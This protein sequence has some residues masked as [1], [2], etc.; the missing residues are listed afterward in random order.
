MIYTRPFL[1]ALYLRNNFYEKWFHVTVMSILIFTCFF[2][3]AIWAHYSSKKKKKKK[4]MINQIQL[5]RLSCEGEI[6]PSKSGVKN[7]NITINSSELTWTSLVIWK[8]SIISELNKEF[9][10]IWL[11]ERYLI[12][13][14]INRSRRFIFNKLTS[15][16]YAS[17]LLLI[18]NF[19][20]TLSK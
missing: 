6:G 16:F 12:W 20:I 5:P 7:C 11:I 9:P 8:F 17:V 15:V 10:A 18:M 3:C 2:E 4:I 1:Q 14:Y 19:V 13:R